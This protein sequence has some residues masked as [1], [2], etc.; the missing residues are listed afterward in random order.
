MG[1]RVLRVLND[2][3]VEAGVSAVREALLRPRHVPV[4]GLVGCSAAGKS[5]LCAALAELLATTPDDVL[6]DYR[7]RADVF[8]LLIS[9]SADA[10]GAR[11]RA[12]GREDGAAIE[13]RVARATAYERV[14][15][16][17]ARVA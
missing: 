15:V 7:A 13:K 10:L 6:R 1:H 16:M 2:G 11:L 14:R 5:T 3:S 8:V 9:A 4:V 17:C 12:R